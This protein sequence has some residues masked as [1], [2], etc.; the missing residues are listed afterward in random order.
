MTKKERHSRE[1]FQI[2]FGEHIT[3]VRKSRGLSIGELAKR[4]FMDKPNLIRIEKGRVNT[5]I[6]Q[7]KKLCD[8]LD[9]TVEN[10]F[11][12]FR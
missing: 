8:A 4:C 12:G 3:K 5:S 7:I 2:E 11:K 1:E 6:Y 10:F 9:L